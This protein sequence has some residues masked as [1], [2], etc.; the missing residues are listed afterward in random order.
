VVTSQS[1]LGI[2]LATLTIDSVS[3]I[4]QVERRPIDNGTTTAVS[5][6]GAPLITKKHEY[7]VVGDGEHGVLFGTRREFQRCEDEPIHIPG[8]IQSFGVLIA[9][10]LVERGKFQVRIVSE[11]CESFCQ[12]SPIQLFELDNFLD[13]FPDRYNSTFDAKAWYVQEQYIRTKLGVE[14]VVFSTV[15]RTPSGALLPMSCAVHFV[16]NGCDLLICEFESLNS[17]ELSVTATDPDMP[18]KPVTTLGIQP[19]IVSQEAQM[20]KARPLQLHRL[21]D[22]L[23]PDERS[24][25]E[26]VSIMAQIQQELSACQDFEELLDTAASVV[27]QLT[28]FHRVMVYRFDKSYN[29]QVVAE[30][31]IPEATSDLYKGLHFPASDIPPQARKLYQVNKVRLLFD[32]NMPTARLVCRTAEDMATPLDL[33]HAYLRA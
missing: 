1:S 10:N 21:V 14:P 19:I 28:G 16:G 25:T 4:S 11:N 24:T 26:T 6:P 15:I 12:Y 2:P 17:L 32:R 22:S 3:S 9:I 20:T 27:Q 7:A 5:E 8:A 31:I 23:H 18:S 29:G 33:T 30:T 13:I